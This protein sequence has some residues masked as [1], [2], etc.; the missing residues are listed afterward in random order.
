MYS[1]RL[2]NYRCFDDTGNIDLKPINILV[3]ANSSGKSSFLKCFP[4]LKQTIGNK[5][6]GTFLW[7]GSNVDFKNFDNV[8]KE[9]SSALELEFVIQNF[10]AP[11]RGFYHSLNEVEI[12]VN[13]LLS[14]RENDKNLENLERLKLMFE[15]QVFVISFNNKRQIAKITINGNPLPDDFDTIMTMDTISLLPRFL[16][17]H[18]NEVDEDYPFWCRN[19]FSNN[20]QGSSFQNFRR[21]SQTLFLGSR[22]KTLDYLND[23]MS[24]D[25]RNRLNKQILHDA[26][27]LL[28]LNNIIDAIN[29]RILSLASNITY[30]AP[31]RA[32]AH[33]YYRLQ[34]SSVNDID[35]DGRNL[36]MYL[37]NLPPDELS[38]FQYWT[39]NLFGFTVDVHSMNGNVEMLIQEGGREL[40]N[41]VDVGFGYTQILPVLCVIWK[42][43]Y[44]D[45]NFIIPEI[46]KNYNE[47]IIAIEQP[48]LHLHPRL[49]GLFA[50]MLVK[51][52]DKAR[53]NDRDIRFVIETH[54]ET[55]INKLGELVA[56]RECKENDVNI[57][58]F[59]AKH[60]GMNCYVEKSTFNSDGQLLNWPYGFFSDYVF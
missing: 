32:A 2:K 24:F 6:N 11:K 53:A 57:Y 56:E 12:T 44:Q 39:K 42:S 43:L 46:P 23:E 59:N 28:H 31:F 17:L 21:I 60:E 22:E 36:A 25:D 13:L 3:G 41:M 55:I 4:L 58:I 7:Y 20:S 9:G 26:Y 18:N 38:H 48:E 50:A 1:L 30:I 16:F 27:I 8:L 54:S 10:K 14:S 52:I 37:Y 49:Q 29:Y 51:V 15:D 34:N 47:H 5:R 35:S 33:R 45:E 19:F 40:H